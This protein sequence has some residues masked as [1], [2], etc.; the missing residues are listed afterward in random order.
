MKCSNAA[1]IC[2]VCDTGCGQV[3]LFET[4]GRLVVIVPIRIKLLFRSLIGLLITS[5][6]KKEFFAMRVVK[7]AIVA[8]LGLFAC[9]LVPIARADSIPLVVAVDGAFTTTQGEAFAVSYEA[10]LCCSTSTAEN[11]NLVPGTL[12][13]S[14]SGPMGTFTPI[15][16]SVG[17]HGGAWKDAS[18]DTIAL[19]LF[20]SQGC[21]IDPASICEP[22]VQPNDY[23]PPGTDV[24]ALANGFFSFYPS[25]AGT[26]SENFFGDVRVTE[27]PVPEPCTLLL[28]SS[29]LIGLG[30]SKRR[31]R[32]RPSSHPASSNV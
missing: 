14:S 18:G 11:F 30:L 27:V 29:G 26:P 10:V 31:F 25:G 3:V 21:M 7:L 23:I 13:Y 24:T 22:E 1:I 6:L 28:L 16:D 17:P 12:A 4:L 5:G 32:N 19:S 20:L 8:A 2:S 9:V 15:L